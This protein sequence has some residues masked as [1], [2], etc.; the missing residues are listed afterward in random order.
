MSDG[1]EE[2]QYEEQR[3]KWEQEK[4]REDRLDHDSGDRWQPE[5]KES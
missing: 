1:E 3:R 4:D 2:R 5:R